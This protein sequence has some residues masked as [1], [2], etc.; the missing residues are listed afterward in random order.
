MAASKTK[1][2]NLEKSLTALETIVASGSGTIGYLAP[3]QALGQP[4]LRSDV[5]ATAL[6]FWQMLSGEIPEWPF[7]WP[8]EGIDKVRRKVHGDVIEWLRR[9]LEV[10]QRARF[11]DGIQM[12]NAYRRLKSAGKL[13]PASS[14]PRKAKKVTSAD[15][16]AVRRKLFDRQFR[17]ELGLIH[18]CGRCGGRMGEEMKGCPWC[19][20]APAKYRG[21]TRLNAR[22]SRCGRGRKA[23]WRFCAWCYG[24]AFKTVS[25]RSYPDKRYVSRCTNR[26]CGK[27]LMAFM[28][29]CPWCRSKV[30]KRW[31]FTGAD[32][33]C[34]GCGGGI[35]KDFWK[36]CPWCVRKMKG[37]R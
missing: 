19:G 17:T 9:A 2:P 8:P 33:R 29:Y 22:C 3:E 23:D 15:W 6:V 13:T 12:L 16:R 35:V 37:R 32:A 30:R 14:K 25:A 18:E 11:R 1:Q 36:W 28:R 26:N 34:R 4:T 24:G 5:F 20:H 10:D 7:E 27:D 21:A 31:T